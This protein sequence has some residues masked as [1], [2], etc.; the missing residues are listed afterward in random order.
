MKG[1][2]IFLSPVFLSVC[3]PVRPPSSGHASESTARHTPINF[4]PSTIGHLD[5]LADLL[6]Q[7]EFR[8]WNESLLRPGRLSSFNI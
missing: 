5:Y 2:P 3:L 7:L 8:I 1:N 4:Q 6:Q